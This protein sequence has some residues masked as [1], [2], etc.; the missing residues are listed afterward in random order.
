MTGIP[1]TLSLLPETFAICRLAPDAAIPAWAMQRQASFFAI[2]Q[3]REELSIICL[4]EQV[5]TDANNI[6]SDTGWRC[7]KLEG[8]FELDEP[9]V[10]VSLASPLAQAGISVFAEATYDTDYLLVNQLDKAIQTL[11]ALQH[12]IVKMPQVVKN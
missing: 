3:T 1:R 9:G 8:P 2:T 10:M 6:L 12:R 5:P 4:Q 7:L 11:E